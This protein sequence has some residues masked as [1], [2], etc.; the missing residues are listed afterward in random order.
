VNDDI[1]NTHV[2]FLTDGV[3]S[4]GGEFVEKLP[5]LQSLT[6]TVRA[7]A[8]SN[9]NLDDL[10][11]LDPKA[12]AFT[13]LRDFRTA[14]SSL[15]TVAD[16]PF[17]EVGVPGIR[18]FLDQ[19]FNCL[20]DPGE[21]VVTT[22]ADDPATPEIDEA[23]RY[24]FEDLPMGW[25]VIREEMRDGSQQ[26][27]PIQGAFTVRVGPSE[28]E[29]HGLGNDFGNR[30]TGGIRGVVFR[31]FN[32]NGLQD[33]GEPGVPGMTVYL[34]RDG[35]GIH[36]DGEPS[37]V[38]AQSPAG[39]YAFSGLENGNYLVRVV[40]RLD[41]GDVSLGRDG[42]AL[43]VNGNTVDANF[44]ITQGTPDP[45]NVDPPDPR[46]ERPTPRNPGRGAAEG[47]IP[48]RELGAPIQSVRDPFISPAGGRMSLVPPLL[49][50]PSVPN[51]QPWLQAIEPD[52]DE[53]LPALAEV[54]SPGVFDPDPG[55]P[56]PALRPIK[57]PD[58]VAQTESDTGN[59]PSGKGAP[60]DVTRAGGPSLW[61]WSLVPISALTAGLSWWFGPRVWRWSAPYFLGRAKARAK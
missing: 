40:P 16:I 18:I 26:T 28:V 49:P 34:D 44:A 29:T 61:L 23:G 55:D 9:T 43:T 20:I 15:R 58:D 25:Y 1:A 5:R 56:P 6:S 45:T 31:D 11:R 4:R 35:D 19:N 36:D 41:L 33:A 57:K 14:M 42:Q 54:L 12:T 48:R 53:L 22:Q 50:E 32:R 47:I 17:T 46:I 8:T 10:K 24:V 13:N 38:S 52:I 3:S 21:R 2:I 30:L 39:A 60:E 7:L 27:A 59:P 51:R 37:I